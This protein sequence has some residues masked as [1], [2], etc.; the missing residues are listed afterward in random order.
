M[1]LRRK[2]LPLL[3]ATLGLM[4]ACGGDVSRAEDYAPTRLL[5]LGDEYNI[6]GANKYSINDS[7]NCAIYPVWVQSLAAH[8]GMGFSQCPNGL[9]T[10]AT[11]YATAGAKVA[12][13]AA[14]ATTAG[15]SF[16]GTDLVTLMVGANDVKEIAAAGGDEASLIS[17][18]RSRGETLA[19][20]VAD[21]VGKGARVIVVTVPDLGK[22]PYGL[23][24]ANPVLLTNVGSAFNTGLR[25]RLDDLQVDGRGAA[26]VLAD[27][28]VQAAVLTPAN[29][30][31][32]GGVT[33]T[34][35]AC[36]TPAPNCTT[37]TLVAG[38]SATTWMWASDIYL[39]PTLQARLGTLAITRAVNNPF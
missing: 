30:G 14:Q 13:A 35:A 27:S 4:S 28:M 29:Y 5:A 39:A 32:A 33:L 24:T 17:T 22:S 31:L 10:N 7:A 26:I 38:A 11:L 36:A 12:D 3:L 23:A 6:V 15:S 21:L 18:A 1:N 8:Y 16:V 37:G 34:Q 20:L 2:A 19:T 9:T 25:V